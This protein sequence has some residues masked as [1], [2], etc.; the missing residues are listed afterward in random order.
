M[1]WKKAGESHP[2]I[3]SPVD[4]GGELLPDKG[5]Y[6]PIRCLNPAAPEA[7]LNLV[8]CGYKKWCAGKCGCHKNIPCTEMCGCVGYRCVNQAKTTD[9][10][11]LDVEDDDW[12]NGH[13]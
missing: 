8:R 9:S 7:V 10:P 6:A 1:I 2:T 11:L 5:I 13:T 12:E 4:Y 3:S